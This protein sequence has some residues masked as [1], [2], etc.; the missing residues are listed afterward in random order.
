VN[1]T[2][3]VRL[4]PDEAGTSRRALAQIHALALRGLAQANTELTRADEE[5]DWE[6]WSLWRGYRRALLEVLAVTDQ[7]DL[8]AA[9][10]GRRRSG[11]VPGAGEGSGARPA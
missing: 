11:A 2:N 10:D 9:A 1:E 7:L 3:P 8:P 6:S 4:D 5:E